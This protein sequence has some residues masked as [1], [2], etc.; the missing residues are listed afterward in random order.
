M[1]CLYLA[2]QFFILSTPP[3]NCVHIYETLC[4]AVPRCEI[5][6]V[7]VLVFH[8]KVPYVRQYRFWS[9]ETEVWI[10]MFSHDL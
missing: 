4:N 6:P 2:T 7:L 9:H 8:D 3:K 10:H 5:E 1:L